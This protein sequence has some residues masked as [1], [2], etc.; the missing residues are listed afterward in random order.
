MITDKDNLELAI[1]LLKNAVTVTE[2]IHDRWQKDWPRLDPEESRLR[3][4]ES[5]AGKLIECVGA[6][7]G[8]PI[9]SNANL[10]LPPNFHIHYM[11]LLDALNRTPS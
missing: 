1:G 8:Q 10:S 11:A 9:I 3:K 4:I 5:A 2:G 7:R 6:V